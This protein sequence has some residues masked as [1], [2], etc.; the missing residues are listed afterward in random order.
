MSGARAKAILTGGLIAGALD[1]TY[2]CTHYALVFGTPPMRIFQ[3]VAA[4]ALG[5][6][7]AVGGGWGTAALGLALHFAIALIMALV[8]V[9]IAQR[10][11]V[12]LR[13]WPITALVYGLLLY[14]VMNYVVVPNSAAGGGGP[15]EGQFFWGALFAHIALVATPIVLAA[16]AYLR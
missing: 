1:I 12:L 14:A 10:V 11:R 4:G 15:P 3:S 8:F 2:A 16:R 5:R 7:A 13:L 6:E 9:T